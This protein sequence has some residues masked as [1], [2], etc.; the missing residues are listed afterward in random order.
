MCTDSLLGLVW[1]PKVGESLVGASWRF[2]GIAWRTL[3]IQVQTVV[4]DTS[5]VDRVDSNPTP[6]SLPM[7]ASV[8]LLNIFVAKDRTGMLNSDDTN[9]RNKNG[10]LRT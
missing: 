3:G 1:T 9:T 5:L 4:K 6:R 10:A 7:L 8:G 2:G